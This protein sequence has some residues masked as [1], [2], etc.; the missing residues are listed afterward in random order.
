MASDHDAIYSPRLNPKE[1]PEEY[2][3]LPKMGLR[4]LELYVNNRIKPGDFLTGVLEN[5]L[6][7]ACA[8]ADRE[9]APLITL[10]AKL[11]YNHTPSPCWGRPGKVRTWLS[12]EE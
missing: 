5:D 10:W 1:L 3:A 8:H 7:K 12:R 11:I 4:S 2:Q 9:N 6:Q